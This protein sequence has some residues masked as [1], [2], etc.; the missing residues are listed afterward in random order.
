MNSRAKTNFD[1]PS[2]QMWCTTTSRVRRPGP[3]RS[4][5]NAIGGSAVRSKASLPD[6]ARQ[7]RTAA[8]SPPGGQGSGTISY[9]MPA[10][11]RPRRQRRRPPVTATSV[12]S[13]GCRPTIARQ[14][15]ATTSSARSP[16]MV[17][18]K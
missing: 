12:R 2:K 16:A 6:V 9:A 11:R 5:V 14:A 15:R 17:A 7:A 10:V 4:S 18:A 3:C 8:R 13:A 1:R